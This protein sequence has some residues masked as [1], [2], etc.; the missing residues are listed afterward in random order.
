M[1]N[2]ETNKQ[3][4]DMINV[5]VDASNPTSCSNNKRKINSLDDYIA[6]LD[7]EDEVHGLLG[8]VTKSQR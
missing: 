6:S 4:T 7:I 8:V 2:K 5:K 1:S 3:L